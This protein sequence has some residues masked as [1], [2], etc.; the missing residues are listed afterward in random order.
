M[1]DQLCATLW[2]SQSQL[3]VKQPGIKPVSI[4]TP[5]ALRCSFLDRCAS[6][7]LVLVVA[8]RFPLMDT[9]LFVFGRHFL[10]LSL[11]FM[12]PEAIGLRCRNA[13]IQNA[14]LRQ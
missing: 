14:G 5:L 8:Y 12:F 7:V 11:M 6:Q 9:C 4:G 13:A 1:L 3:V 10:M 2:D